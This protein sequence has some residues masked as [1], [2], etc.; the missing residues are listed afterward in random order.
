MQD[1][2]DIGQARVGDPNYVQYVKDRP[3]AILWLVKFHP[4]LTDD[5]RVH[6]LLLDEERRRGR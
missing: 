3:N 2:L 1:L 4:E 5:Q 6:R